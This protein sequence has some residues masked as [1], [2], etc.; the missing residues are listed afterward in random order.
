M[1]SSTVSINPT[2]PTQQRPP[3]QR[4]PTSFNVQPFTVTVVQSREGRQR[5]AACMLGP[6]KARVLQAPV[7]AVFA[8]DLGE[9]ACPTEASVDG[10]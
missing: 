5:L 6:N 3:P 2:T 4:C 7:T 1:F 10:L 8:A 9:P